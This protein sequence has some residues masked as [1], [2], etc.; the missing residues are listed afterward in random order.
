MN[1]EINILT[2]KGITNLDI[3]LFYFLFIINFINNK[4]SFNDSS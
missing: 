1:L 3:F 4:N 2:K